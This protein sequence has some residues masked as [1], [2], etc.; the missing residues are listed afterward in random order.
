[1]SPACPAQPFPILRT[2]LIRLVRA[3][4]AVNF[5][6]RQ[7]SIF[8][9]ERRAAGE[10]RPF[11]SHLV[12][13]PLGLENESEDFV[14]SL[15]FLNGSFSTKWDKLDVLFKELLQRATEEPAAE[16][17]EEEEADE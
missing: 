8:S 9:E 10:A 13:V 3:H 16:E 2:R 7:A 15:G 14:D 5:K 12:Y 1:M 4:T 6:I 11:E 17:D